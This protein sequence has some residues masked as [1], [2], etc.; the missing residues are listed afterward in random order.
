[1]PTTNTYLI[2]I[3]GHLPD[4][5]AD[6]FPNLRLRAEPGGD[7]SLCGPVLDQAALFGILH[8]IASLGLALVSVNPV[9]NATLDLA[10]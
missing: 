6:R 3:H 7:T 10:N 2:R 4:T 5:W 9:P 1:M 8:Q